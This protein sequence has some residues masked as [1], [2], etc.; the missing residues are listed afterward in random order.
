MEPETTTVNI[1][2]QDYAL[3]GGEDAE[4][5]RDVAAHVDR[6]MREVARGSKQV[7]SLRVAILA[8][9]NIAEDLLRE[10]NTNPSFIHFEER[11]T[12]MSAALEESIQ[13]S[14]D[15]EATATSGKKNGKGGENLRD[16]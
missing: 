13:L 16:A 2:G 12:K 6:R 7:S 10:R 14:E 3:R 1:F 11:A 15:D 8:A 9:M 5:V 4:H